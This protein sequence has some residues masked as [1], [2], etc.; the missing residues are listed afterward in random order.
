MCIGIAS[1]EE[2]VCGRVESIVFHVDVQV[3]GQIRS[4]VKIFQS[5]RVFLFDL[6]VSN[7]VSNGLQ[8]VKNRIGDVMLEF[9]NAFCEHIEFLF[10]IG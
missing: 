3:F 10:C 7:D 6:K 4:I 5:T 1:I 2:L 8:I 9:L